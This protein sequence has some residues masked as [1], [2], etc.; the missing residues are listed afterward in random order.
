MPSFRRQERK[1]FRPRAT[2]LVPIPRTWKS[3]RTRIGEFR[4]KEWKKTRS[5]KLAGRP[6]PPVPPDRRPGCGE[7]GHAECVSD[8]A[9]RDGGEVAAT[10]RDLRGPD[11]FR[12]VETGGSPA[13]SSGRR[14]M[15]FVR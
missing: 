3:R 12:W 4:I 13:D 5:A 9:D 11:R 10:A 15:M 6:F 2:G 8:A 7:S 1:A 14:N